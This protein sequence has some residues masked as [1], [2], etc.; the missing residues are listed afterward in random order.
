MSARTSSLHAG[1]HAAPTPASA[2]AAA[3][4][5][6][7]HRDRPLAMLTGALARRSILA[8]AAVFL[9]PPLPSVAESAAIVARGSVALQKNGAAVGSDAAGAA[10]YVTAKPAD[11]STGVFATAGKVPPLAAARFP[12]PLEFPYAF[13][14]STDNLTPEF[15]SVPSQTWSGTDL[16]IT[17]RYDTD[18]VAA[19]RGPDDLVGRATLIKRG[20]ADPGGWGPAV[21]E[22]QGRGMAGKLLTGGK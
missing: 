6:A 12:S 9:R 8:A 7:I 21:V 16:V 13:E 15:S 4:D 3:C 22:L 11:S 17:A 2:S 1:A 20:A 10:L 18:G 19:T 5:L 14:L